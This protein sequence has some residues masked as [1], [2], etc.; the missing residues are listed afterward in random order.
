MVELH[1]SISI[2]VYSRSLYL[3]PKSA[4]SSLEFHLAGKNSSII[5]FENPLLTFSSLR[6]PKIIHS[7]LSPL[8]FKFKFPWNIKVPNSIRV[9][10]VNQEKPMSVQTRVTKLS[11][12]TLQV[13]S[14]IFKQSP[15]PDIV[16]YTTFIKFLGDSGYATEAHQLFTLMRESHEPDTILFTVLIQILCNSKMYGQALDVFHEMSCHNCKPDLFCYNVLINKLGE[17]GQEDA[18]WKL[19][20]KMQLEGIYP[21]VVTYSAVVK[22][23]CLSENFNEA[24]RVLECMEMKKSVEPPNT[25]TYN[26]IIKAF[27]DRKQ[28]KEALGVVGRMHILGLEPDS[29][30]FNLFIKYYSDLGEGQEAYSLLR[31]MITT[32]IEINEASYVTCLN[33]LMKQGQSNEV[34]ELVEYIRQSNIVI[35]IRAW[36]KLIYWFSKRDQLEDGYGIFLRLRNPNEIT[37]NTVIQML[38][39][40]G[41]SERAWEVLKLMN[42]KK[43][44]A[45]VVTYNILLHGLCEQGMVTRGF[46][47]VLEMIVKGLKPDLITYNTLINGL[48]KAG[49]TEDASN[50]FEIM[51]GRFTVSGSDSLEKFVK[52]M[53]IKEKLH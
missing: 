41:K 8:L 23:L 6:V 10:L 4:I 42:E 46:K 2:G 53:L 43:I 49:R 13:L 17:M 34:L 16:T 20:S 30:S 47:I 40:H 24:F 9:Q 38:Y 28:I 45:S 39:K 25:Y 26:T 31:F 18:L 11:S 50:L 22:S 32:G 12:P 37:M 7:I 21:D 48:I 51:R 14:Q 52:E 27:L 44:E 5:Q 36:N 35:N 3:V 33:G 1:S 29:I 15:S 19:F